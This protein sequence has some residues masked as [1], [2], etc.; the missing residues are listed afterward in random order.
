MLAKTQLCK[1]KIVFLYLFVRELP[2]VGD[3]ITLVYF[4]YMEIFAIRNG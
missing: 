2:A 3:L 4:S 1:K